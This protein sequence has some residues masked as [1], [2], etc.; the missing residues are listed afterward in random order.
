MQ[1][2]Y[3]IPA[4]AQEIAIA[5]ALTATLDPEINASPPDVRWPRAM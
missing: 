3:L 1:R 4:A 2:I 5:D